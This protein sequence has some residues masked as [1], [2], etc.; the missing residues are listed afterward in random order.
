MEPFLESKERR[1]DIDFWR[2]ISIFMVY[3][4]HVG[5]PFNGDN[6]HIMNADSSKVLDDIMVYFEQ[7]RLPLLF[8]ISGV[9]TVYAFSKRSAWQFTKERASRLLIPLIFAVFVIVPPQY[10]FEHYEE[11]TSF[12]DVYLTVFD[13]LDV[14]HLW[15]IEN[16]FYISI[17][18]I[19][20]ILFIK[21]DRSIR[22]R[23]H[24]EGLSEKPYGMLLWA[25]PLILLRVILKVYFPSNSN[26]LMNP[27][28]SLY[29]IYFFLSG[30]LLSGSPAIWANIKRHR[31]FFLKVMIVTSICFY[32]YYFL[33][34]DSLSQYLSIAERWHIW[35][36][37]SAF[38]SWTLILTALA[39]GQVF[40]TK[41]SL[42]L[43]KLNEGIYP[44]YILH[45]TVIIW[46]GF[47]VI[48][49]D[50]GIGM[51]ILALL[52]ISFPLILFIY[53][54]LILPF[55]WV[56]VLFGMKGPK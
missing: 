2:V 8:L 34:D 7:F 33:P 28:S 5:M 18:A 46:I 39:Y 49:W 52:L 23:A 50:L 51:K 16:L 21:S 24:L 35:Y 42:L 17:A 30:I 26:S 54:F 13:Y 11:F 19:P 40:I 56:R 36:A 20:L 9:G 10:Y 32:A 25:L 47:Y 48:Q 55:G 27:S 45:Q 15:F 38:L 37:L 29:Y 53:R 43:T 14:N 1:Y 31:T 44:F 22:F 41:N 6:F 3:L 4:H 12:W